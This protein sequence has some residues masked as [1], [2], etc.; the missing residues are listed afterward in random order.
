MSRSEGIEIA[1]RALDEM[2]KAGADKAAASFVRG[3]Q[4]ELNADAGEFSLF[5]STVNISL[6]MTAYCETRKGS[7]SINSYDEASI[8]KAAQDAVEMA[9][10]SE[11]DPAN[12]I[13]PASKLEE[14]SFGPAQAESDLMYDRLNDLIAYTKKEYPSINLEQ[15][16]L[17]FVRKEAF[18]ANSNGAEFAESS[19]IYGFFA[20][21]S[22]KEGQD[23]SSFNY[24]GANHRNLDKALKDWGNIDELLRQSTEQLRLKPV[25]GSFI[26]DILITP[27][28]LG[29]FLG[30][31]NGTYTGTYPL[32]SGTS[33]WKD[34]LESQVVSPLVTIR[35]LPLGPEVDAGYS[36]TADGFRAENATLIDNGV[37]K[38][39]TLGLYGS[40]KTG[41]PR[42]PS[43]GGAICMDAGNETLDEIL[44]STKKGILLGRFSGGNPSSNGD[45]SGVAKNSYLIEDG[46]IARPVSETMIAGNLASF[47]ESIRAVSKERVD[48]GSGILPWVLGSGVHISGK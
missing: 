32:I 10:A 14:F 7:I 29:D 11:P 2:K 20:M 47:F 18:W 17:D 25:D 38:F 36:F 48:Y 41:K 43:G 16:I 13:S 3:E 22:A 42:C 35:S 1:R 5:R 19:G 33:P 12:E 15:C 39:F 9:R 31:L 8:R 26:G 6:G 37:L 34:K 4:N 27:D 46:K 21:F 40:R 30:M 24:S 44:G 45:F 23:A 28:C